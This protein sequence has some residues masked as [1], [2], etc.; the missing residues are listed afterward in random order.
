VSV[1]KSGLRCPPKGG[2]KDQAMAILTII[3]RTTQTVYYAVRLWID[4]H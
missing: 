3:A 4:S 2:K 1:D